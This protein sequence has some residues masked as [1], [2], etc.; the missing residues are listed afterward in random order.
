M[1][2]KKESVSWST[3]LI[4]ADPAPSPNADGSLRPLRFYRSF[5]LPTSKVQ[6]AQIF[7][8]AHGCYAAYVNGRLVT[9]ECMTPG[10][11]SYKHHLHYQTYDISHLLHQSVNNTL[12]VA[13][14]PGWYASALAWARGRRCFFG[15]L[16]GLIVQLEVKLQDGGQYVLC[17]DERWQWATSPLLSSE[18]YNGEVYDAN[19]DETRF[20]L[21]AVAASD[22]PAHELISSD[23]SLPC[24]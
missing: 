20:P 16:L 23:V 22:L 5:E 15:D 24:V 10:W 12:C 6:N 7:I 2:T 21:L 17:T 4:T 9:D 14:A 3:K 19:V 18:L 11:Q 1:A 13:V 8:T